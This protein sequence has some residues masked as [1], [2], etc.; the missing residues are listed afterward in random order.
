M[1]RTMQGKIKYELDYIKYEFAIRINM[2][3]AEHNGF[4]FFLCGGLLA[5]WKQL[6]S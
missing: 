3:C 1:N 4:F 6:K 5:A 2:V